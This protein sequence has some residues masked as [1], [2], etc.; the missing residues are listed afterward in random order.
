MTDIID[1]LARL[2][3]A[4][5][6]KRIG[7]DHQRGDA[8][9][10]E[11]IAEIQGLRVS[12]EEARKGLRVKPLVWRDTSQSF[13]GER[14]SAKTIFGEEYVCLWDDCAMIWSG[15]IWGGWT[16][17]GEEGGLEAAKSAA[18]A[19]YE[20]RILSALEASQ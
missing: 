11:A 20:R 6:T 18:Q 1:K 2:Q 12:A 3:D 17:Y 4:D 14:F 19:D 5:L 10:A 7:I 16:D 13:T 8:V 9:I 15:F